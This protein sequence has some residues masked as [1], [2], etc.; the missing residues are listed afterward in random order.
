MFIELPEILSIRGSRCIIRPAYELMEKRKNKSHSQ[1]TNEKNLKN[2]SPS[3]I[4][5]RKIRLQMKRIIYNWIEIVKKSPILEN[6]YA[7]YYPTFI[8]LT[9]PGEQM[10]SDKD[11]HATCL[12]RFMTMIKRTQGVKNYVWRAERQENG[13]LHYHI[14]V[15]KFIGHKLVRQY[16][17]TIMEDKG[18]IDIYRKN[19]SKTHEKGFK[20]IDKKNKKWNYNKQ[21][22]AYLQGVSENWS[23]PNSTD[24]HSLKN[25]EDISSY[26]CKYT[27]KGDEYDKMEQ[28]KKSLENNSIDES[29]YNEQME[30]VEEK[31]SKCK[32]DGRIWGCSDEIK[33]I[34]DV[35]LIIGTKEIE[36]IESV[37][38]SSACRSVTTDHA[39]IL[40]CKEIKKILY[41][42]P[43][44]YKQVSEYY[45]L[46]FDI[47][48]KDF[49]PYKEPEPVWKLPEKIESKSTIQDMQLALFD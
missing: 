27:T 22:K 28:L 21:Y 5:N 10:H 12:N 1:L 40:Y 17:N 33:E 8:T 37:S 39:T 49:H 18:Y 42:H 48:Y 16:W 13:N 41:K 32:I 7:E 15:D 34:K 4:M 44:V 19:Q 20:Y 6:G 35:S 38:A 25:I 11:L 46:H 2:N 14:I 23:N 9:L 47:I 3:G 29:Y 43:E 31:I 24:I 45:Q 26:I 30:I 36:Y